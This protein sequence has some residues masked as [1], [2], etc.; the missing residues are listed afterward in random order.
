MTRWEEGKGA[1]HEEAEGVG[2][3]GD[4]RAAAGEEVGG[5]EA[6]EAERVGGRGG[7]GADL[8]DLGAHGG[9]AC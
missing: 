5:C 3:V 7:E 6:G 8:G 2:G 1:Y 4:E 9:A